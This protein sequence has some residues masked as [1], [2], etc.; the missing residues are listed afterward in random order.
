[1][2]RRHIVSELSVHL[3]PKKNRGDGG[4]HFGNAKFGSVIGGTRKERVVH[5]QLP[6]AQS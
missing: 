2:G 5:P 6:N 3:P 1:M 4:K